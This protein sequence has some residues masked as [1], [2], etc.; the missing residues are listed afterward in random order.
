MKKGPY[1]WEG[2]SSSLSNPAHLEEV[3]AASQHR[4]HPSTLIVRPFGAP[5]PASCRRCIMLRMVERRQAVVACHAFCSAN[6]S[7]MRLRTSS[8][9]ADA[10]LSLSLLL[11]L[12]LSVQARPAY[13]GG[14][15]LVVADSKD[16]EIK[17]YSQFWAS[18][19]GD[20]RRR[21]CPCQAAISYVEIRS[22][23]IHLD[24][25][26][27]QEHRSEQC[28]ALDALRRETV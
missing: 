11:L 12:P 13:G 24:F 4:A 20:L 25:P 26:R 15:L 2:G 21:N 6:T 23:W 28:R 19:E 7:K 8:L 3:V 18:L 22:P 1:G 14:K 17:D 27:P 16:L 5:S 9:V 10:L